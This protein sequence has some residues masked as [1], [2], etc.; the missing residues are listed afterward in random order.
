MQMNKR[1]KKN[2]PDNGL[3][4]IDWTSIVISSLSD[5]SVGI[6]LIIIGKIVG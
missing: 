5:L 6:I 3:H 1:P 4:N 2:K